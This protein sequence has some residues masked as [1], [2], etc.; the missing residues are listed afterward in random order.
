LYLATWGIETST[1]RSL[2]LT[3]VKI[4]A[5][6]FLPQQ[7]IAHFRHPANQ[8]GFV[9]IDFIQV[10]IE[11]AAWDTVVGMQI[12][13]K[14]SSMQCGSIV[15]KVSTNSEIK[16]AKYVEVTLSPLLALSWHVS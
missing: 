16:F 4:T 15:I 1:S 12:S 10:E 2:Y 11:L 6:A 3:F 9:N 13:D 7:P 14:A 5:L 8:N